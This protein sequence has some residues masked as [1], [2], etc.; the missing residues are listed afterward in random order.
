LLAFTAVAAL[1][2]S[3][4]SAVAGDGGRVLSAPEARTATT[5]GFGIPLS[6]QGGRTEATVANVDAVYYG[7]TDV[8]NVVVSV[9][10]DRQGKNDLLGSSTAKPPA[11]TKVISVANVVVLYSRSEG[12][13]D[14]SEDIRRALEATAKR[15]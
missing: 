7:G 5:A 6:L 10:D 4:C 12:T 15:A 11:G 14:R 2:F 13:P 8:E 1:G 9:F 3:G